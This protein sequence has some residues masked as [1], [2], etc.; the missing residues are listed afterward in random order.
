APHEEA[1][2]F[3]VDILRETR[4][5]FCTGP[6][7]EDTYVLK[8]VPLSVPGQVPSQ[9]KVAF[10]YGLF[11]AA[12]CVVP[13]GWEHWQHPMRVRLY[14][15]GWETVEIQSWDLAPQ[16]SWKEAADLAAQEKAVD[17]LL[18]D[19]ERAREPGVPGRAW[20]E[21]FRQA[22]SR[23]TFFSLGPLYRFLA[24]G[25]ASAE[26]R[27]VLLFAA[28]EYERLVDSGTTG[29]ADHAVRQRL[30]D[31]GRWLRALAEK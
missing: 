21:E 31:K 8:A 18:S 20:T 22:F 19:R 24:P 13:C 9:I 23:E 7:S 11:F 15:P 2:A 26:H 4:N 25:S 6:C 12:G 1:H 17:D 5:L 3:R 14:R 27:K 30:A 16:M 28:A 29:A 10:D